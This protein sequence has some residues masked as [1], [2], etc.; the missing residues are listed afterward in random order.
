MSIKIKKQLRKKYFA[1]LQILKT[2]YEKLISK[3]LQTKKKQPSLSCSSAYAK[4]VEQLDELNKKYKNSVHFLNDK[5]TKEI[6]QKYK[7]DLKEL[8]M[9][10]LL[11]T[12]D[13]IRSRYIVERNGLTNKYK[14][15]LGNI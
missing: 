2:K 12:L 5:N 15:D 6:N 10:Y 4:Y 8:R 9:N 11:K 7:S 3:D 14:K 13:S 1:D